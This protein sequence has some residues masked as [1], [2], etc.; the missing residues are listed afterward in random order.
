MN[1]AQANTGDVRNDIAEG[2]VNE[3]GTGYV[4]LRSV[5]EIY[6]TIFHSAKFLEADTATANNGTHS[7][8]HHS[9]SYLY[10]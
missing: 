3:C 5:A 8:I 4:Y 10:V 7:N 1:N 2:P 9:L 6:L